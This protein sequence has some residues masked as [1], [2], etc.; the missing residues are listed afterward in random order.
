VIA[1]ANAVG[2]GND[3]VVRPEPVLADT[4]PVDVVTG[5]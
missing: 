1:N 5:Q 4:V 3:Q 2:G